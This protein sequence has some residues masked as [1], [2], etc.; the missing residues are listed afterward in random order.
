[1]RRILLVL[2]LLTDLSTAAVRVSLV[3]DAGLDAPA[4]HGLAKLEAALFAKGF[5]V[6][7]PERV[8]DAD[9]DFVVLAGLCSGGGPAAA[10]LNAE[11]L[12]CPEEAES[13]VV[14]RVEIQGKPGV[15]LAGSDSRGL[16]YAALD[17]AQRIG[18]PGV[19]FA[20]VHNTRESPFVAER[21]VSIYTMQRAYFESRLYDERYWQRYFDMLAASRINSFAVVFGYENGG[22][23]AP[24]YPFFFNVDEFPEVELVGITAQQQAHNVAAFKSMIRI[25]HERGVEVTAAIWDHVYRGGVQGG[26]IQGAS[27]LAGKKTPGLVWGITAE[28]LASYNKAAVRKLLQVFPEIDALQ[29][30]MHAESGLKPEE[31]PQFWHEIFSM[32][33]QVRPN[34]RVDLRA[35][36]LPDSIIEDALNQGLRA[37]VATKYWMEQMG[38]PFH[39]THVNRQNQHDRRHGYADLMKYPQ[40]YKIHWRLWNGGTTR[41]LLWGDP[42]YVRRFAESVH[43][44]SGNSFEVNEMLAT[45]ML[46]E[47]HD[48]APL[49]IMNSPYRD[50]DYEFE[51]YWH[52]Y[53]VWGRVSYN[54]DTPAEV[55]EREFRTRF[56]NEAGI[57]LMRGLHLASKVLPRIVAASYRYRLFPTTRGWAEMT[58][59]GSLP[60]YARDEEGSDT[61]QFMNLREEAKSILDGSDTAQRRP[62]DISRWFSQ[63]SEQILEQVRL[64]EQSP[65]KNGGSESVSTTA[66]LKIL[67]HL[68]QYHAE[69]LLAGLAYNLYRETGDLFA[70]DDAVRYEKR[71]VEAWERIIEAAG[72]VYSGELAFGVH[73]M[74]FPRHW[75]EELPKLREDLQ[76]LEAERRQAKA[77]AGGSSPAIAHVP[78]RR[79][80]PY[81]PLRIRATVGATTP[82]SA[83]RVYI[84]RDDGA[85]EAVPMQPTGDGM[86]S[87]EIAPAETESQIRYA[88]EAETSSGSKSTYPP[89]GKDSPV[90][91]TVTGDHDPPQVSLERARGVKPG[92]DLKIT[93]R[94]EDPSGIRWVR[95]RYRH[96]TQFED[97]E[98]AAMRLNPVTGLYE[99]VIP[100][101]FIVPQWD[102]M[103]F[104]EAVDTKGNGRMY[105]DLEAEMPYVFAGM[106]R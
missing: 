86:Y 13:L 73:N 49:K 100:G 105:P 6:N 103:Y 56:G 31:M 51:R 23:M 38:L 53:Q 8:V 92:A 5:A 67:A 54:P 78:V 44:Y 16:M 84:S 37:R 17:T 65:D 60:E 95:L 40:R 106:D 21:A 30:R 41:L 55:W 3:V 72:D 58:S 10:V 7:R 19:P 69:R 32:I 62:E 18:W 63:V 47:P 2:F 28:N 42:D 102:L 25:A 85:F 27:Q 33:R 90:V 39:P 104:L 70:F 57:H 43:V 36:E 68:A 11:S 1:M 89:G 77:R 66:D 12:T 74:G 46:G 93:A 22:F 91:V 14:R 101:R 71:A 20:H 98:T 4:R 34:L 48:R 99:A 24:P 97:Y 88:I 9:G 50:Y 61:Q 76:K 94:V 80:G 15:V 96:A 83:V 82:V 79:L 87:A 29:F 64:A 26:G 75:R 59:M 81:E 52:F 45:W 35:K